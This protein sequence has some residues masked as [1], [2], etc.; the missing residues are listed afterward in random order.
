VNPDRLTPLQHLSHRVEAD[1][2]FLGYHLALYRDRN[3]LTDDDL[4]AW[5]GLPAG[6]MPKL[7]LCGVPADAAGV[8]PVAG[9]FGCDAGRL[10]EIC[11]IRD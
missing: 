8:S 10:G 2:S 9:R 7:R 3:G 4:A 11:G 5:L 6:E 1:P